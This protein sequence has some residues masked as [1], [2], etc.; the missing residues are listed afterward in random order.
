MVA[1]LLLLCA[2]LIGGSLVH[3]PRTGDIHVGGRELE[4][5]TEPFQYWL[6]MLI[7]TLVFLAVLAVGL[8]LVRV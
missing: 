2:L 7:G 3:A 8:G 4:R 6:S 1:V 5:R